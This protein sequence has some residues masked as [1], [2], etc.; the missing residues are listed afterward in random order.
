[1]FISSAVIRNRIRKTG[2]VKEHKIEGASVVCEISSN[3]GK[4]NMSKVLP[5]VLDFIDCIRYKFS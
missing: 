5:I 3:L 1:M 2:A 4:E